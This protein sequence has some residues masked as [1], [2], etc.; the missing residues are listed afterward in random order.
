MPTDQPGPLSD[1]TSGEERLGNGPVALTRTNVCY[2][3]KKA[4]EMRD[5]GLLSS[6]SFCANAVSLLPKSKQDIMYHHPA[7]KGSNWDALKSYLLE[8][9]GP[10]GEVQ[11]LNQEAETMIQ[12]LDQKI[13]EIQAQLCDISKIKERLDTLSA[14]IDSVEY[15]S[16][17]DKKMLFIDALPDDEDTRFI[18]LLYE[19]FPFTE[20][21]EKVAAKIL[22]MVKRRVGRRLSAR[23]VPDAV[24]SSLTPS[25]QT[26]EAPSSTP[27]NADSIDGLINALGQLI[28]ALC[29]GQGGQV[30]SP[31]ATNTPAAKNGTADTTTARNPHCVYCTSGEHFKS[32]CPML[33]EDLKAKKVCIIGRRATTKA[34]GNRCLVYPAAVWSC[35][36]SQYAEV[37]VDPGSEVGIVDTKWAAIANLPFTKLASE[38]QIFDVCGGVKRSSLL[39]ED[40]HGAIEENARAAK[41]TLA[42]LA[43]QSCA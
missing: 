38:Y 30:A 4:E 37:V 33:M 35:I 16:D 36:G 18:T 41:S 40:V 11:Q 17:E 31:V 1:Q 14:L 10:D 19:D 9:C 32:G 24:S 15:L 23:R 25:H 5:Q 39:C 42:L 20:F 3:L 43:S 2:V 34:I 7:V 22:S 26:K 13:K 29:V 12:R 27:C 21:A 8:S 6:G 28:L